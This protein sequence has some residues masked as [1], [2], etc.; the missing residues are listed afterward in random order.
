MQFDDW[1]LLV[2]PRP[3]DVCGVVCVCVRRTVRD[4][5]V[6]PIPPNYAVYLVHLDGRSVGRR[7]LVTA[8]DCWLDDVRLLLLLLLMLMLLLHKM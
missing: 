1:R 6:S 7:G 3:A 4:C 2:Y 5:I 8:I